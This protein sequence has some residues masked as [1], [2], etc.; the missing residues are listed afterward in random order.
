MVEWRVGNMTDLSSHIWYSLSLVVLRAGQV[1]RICS[2]VPG[3]EVQEG[4]LQKPFLFLLQCLHSISVL[5]L[6]ETN[7]AS[8]LLLEHSNGLLAAMLHM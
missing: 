5:Y 6:P 8:T 3:V 7:L 4:A 2:I 1:A